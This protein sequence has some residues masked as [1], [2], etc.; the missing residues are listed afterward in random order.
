[1]KC[2]KWKPLLSGLVDGELTPEEE[3]SLSDHLSH[4]P[5][6][7]DELEALRDLEGVTAAMKD[8][9]FAPV[10]DV[11][12]DRYWMSI[13]NRIERGIGWVLLSAGAAT[14]V[15]FGLWHFATAFLFASEAPLVARWGVGLGAAGLGVLIVSLVRERART[16]RR[17]PYKEVKR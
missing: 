9:T 3:A 7:R 5:G 17:D 16:Y 8:E 2:Q 1:M 14:L 6:C 15:A 11:F 4:C 10:N 12:W 13:Y